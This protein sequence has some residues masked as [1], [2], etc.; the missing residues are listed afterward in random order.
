MPKRLIILLL[1]FKSFSLSA[2]TFG[3]YP[4]SQKWNNIRISSA[5]IIFPKGWDST[6]V[7]VAS[8]I[9]SIKEI[10]DSSIGT[11]QLPINIILQH[12]TTQSNGYVALAPFRSEFMMAPPAN[13]FELGSLAW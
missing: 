12:G 7:R 4:P 2:Q 3:G 9:E 13:P 1:I 5:R 10:K 11:R 8:L 6:A